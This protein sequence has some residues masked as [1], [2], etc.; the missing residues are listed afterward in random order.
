[1]TEN[2]E[3]QT[4]LSIDLFNVSGEFE[5]IEFTINDAGNAE[6]QAIARRC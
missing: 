2:T 3:E 4:E 1:M 6:M 5:D